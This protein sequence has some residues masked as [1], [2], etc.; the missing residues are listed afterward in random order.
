MRRKSMV[1]LAA[2]LSCGLFAACGKNTDKLVY[3]KD[4]QAKDFVK[5]GEYKGVEIDMAQPLVSD[6][7]LDA[8]IDNILQNSAVSVPV[9]GRTAVEKGDVANIDYEGKLDGVAFA[10][11]T[12][13][14]F[15][16]TIGSGRFID[17]F[18]DGIIGMQV[19]ET[20]DLNLTFPDP[21]SNADLAGKAVVFTVTVN[22]IGSMEIPELT[23]A[24]V[25]D[26][27]IE[28]CSNVQ[29]YREFVRD[30]LLKQKQAQ[31]E[32]EKSTL[33]F[34]A[35]VENAEFKKAPEG[36]VKRMNESLV[37]NLTQQASAYGMGLAE[38]VALAYGSSEDG[39]RD[40]LSEQA[41]LMAQ[42]YI[43]IAAIADLEGITV[44]DEELEKEL[45]EQFE[46]AAQI[47]GY[48]SVDAYKAELTDLDEEAYREYMLME[49][50]TAWISENADVHVT[51][52]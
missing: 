6:E 48:E 24:Y 17:G 26:M 22:S 43:L 52:Q 35:A 40:L 51:V 10:G 34:E 36:M 12:A 9:E 41:E 8:Y 16:L 50:V 31:Y 25:K 4:F 19:G 27:G 38:Y 33:A 20:R 11:G 13:Q 44:T 23:D 3:L 49:K 30:N 47:Y 37:N 39:Y 14:G 5:T 7:E 45:N 21:Y 2:V 42:R 18:E 29:E 15:D 1:I 46:M 28:E 32:Q